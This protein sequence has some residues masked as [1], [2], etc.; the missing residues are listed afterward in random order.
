MSLMTEPID[1]STLTLKNRLVRSA[2]AESMSDRAGFISD[3]YLKLYEKLARGG[4]A[5]IITGHIFFSK[6][7]RPAENSPLLDDDNKI[8]QFKKVTEIVHQNGSKIFAQLNHSGREALVPIAPL[9]VK[10][11]LTMVKPREMT[12]SEILEVINK[13][14]ESARR[15]KLAG[16]DGIQIHGAHGYLVN[17]FLSA[18]INQRKDRWGGN[19]IE[20][21]MRFLL[22]VY[23]G[24]REEVGADFPVILKI[25][26]SDHIKNGTEMQDV[27]YVLKRLEE[28]GLDAVEISGGTHESG[29]YTVRGTIPIKELLQKRNIM[30]KLIGTIKLKN[31]AK[32]TYLQEGYNLQEAGAIKEQLKI[33]VICVGGMRDRIFIEKV[34]QENQVDMVAFARPLIREP[35]LPKKFLEGTRDRADCISCNQCLLALGPL[36]CR[37]KSKE[38]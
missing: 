34:L 19:T 26:G 21:R 36:K 20:K 14:R 27:V 22:K 24:I 10:N 29:F 18:R 6:D 4:A 37:N 1:I 7:G 35:F 9:K 17:Q 15:A 13:F 25:N 12:E 28:R 11:S 8:E 16:F 5:L 33:P 30:I 31:M 2:T 3:Q 32:K 23:D 38:S